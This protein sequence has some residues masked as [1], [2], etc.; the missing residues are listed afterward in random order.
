MEEAVKQYGELG[1]SG[2]I[3]ALVL[4]LLWKYVPKLIETHLDFVAFAKRQ[5]EQ[6]LQLHADNI[7][8]QTDH[9]AATTRTNM[10]LRHGCNLLEMAIRGTAKEDELARHVRAIRDALTED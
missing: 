9:A 10:A 5:G 4:F 8:R 3:A 2:G 6:I 1:L 7:E